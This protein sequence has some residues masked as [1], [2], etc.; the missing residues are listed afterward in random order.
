MKISQYWQ[1]LQRS[2]FPGFDQEVGV[3]TPAHG[4]VMVILDLI[5]FDPFFYNSISQKGRPPSCR[6]AL[7]RAFVAKSLALL[8]QKPK[9]V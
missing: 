3:Q 7:A 6:F 5:D 1:H 2:L 8:C 4:H 9:I